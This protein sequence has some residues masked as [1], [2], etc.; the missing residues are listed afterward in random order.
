ML[1]ILIAV[2]LTGLANNRAVEVWNHS[3]LFGRPRRW[4]KKH[5]PWFFYGLLTCPFCLSF[6][7]GLLLASVASLS[8]G[9]CLSALPI[10]WLASVYVSNKLNDGLN[11]KTPKANYEEDIEAQIL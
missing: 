10:T 11:D 6:Y 4:I 8:F 3:A 1:D 5:K 2:L 9:L 7:T